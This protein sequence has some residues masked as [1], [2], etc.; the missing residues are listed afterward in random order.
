MISSIQVAHRAINELINKINS[1]IKRY[2]DM[3][4]EITRLFIS[5]HN[6]RTSPQ[7]LTLESLKRACKDEINQLRTQTTKIRKDA[8]I[9]S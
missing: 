2:D 4:A 3:D 6:P 1:L 8:N 7:I 9:I 5:G